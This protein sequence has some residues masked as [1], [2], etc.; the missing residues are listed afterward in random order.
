MEFAHALVGV[1]LLV[2]SALLEEVTSRGEDLIE[3]VLV[4]DF[5]GLDAPL[6]LHV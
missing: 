5:D 4:T 1:L 6:G 2:L 3:D